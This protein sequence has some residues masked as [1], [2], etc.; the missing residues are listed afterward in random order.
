MT[1]AE[2]LLTLLF[3]KT[4]PVYDRRKLTAVSE[5]LFQC[6]SDYTGIKPTPRNRKLLSNRIDGFVSAIVKTNSLTLRPMIESLNLPDEL[7]RLVRLVCA[8][9]YAP[10]ALYDE[11]KA[12]L[13]LLAR[14]TNFSKKGNASH[15]RAR[16]ADW[17]EPVVQRANELKRKNRR[18]TT[19][20]IARAIHR[21]STVNPTLKSHASIRKVLNQ[22]R[23]P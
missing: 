6:A 1:N 16:Q 7:E 23:K 8:I 21:D 12:Y 14:D 15:E 20:A 5:R 18:L 17:I 19:S 2:A 13:H 10:D 11:I 3:G 9:R 22:W 4:L